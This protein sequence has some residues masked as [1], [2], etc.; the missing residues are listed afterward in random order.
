MPSF[1]SLAPTRLDSS[2]DMSLERQRL[3]L[4]RD[5][6]QNTKDQQR[7]QMELAQMEEGG[8]MAREKMIQ[9]RQLAEQQAA[10]SAAGK[11]ESSAALAKFTE[12]NGQGDIEGARAMVPLMTQLGMQVDLLGEQDGL[13]AYQIGPD[14]EAGSRTQGVIGYPQTDSSPMQAPQGIPSTADAFQQALAS[15]GQPAKPPDQPD[16]TGAVPKNVID[17]GAIHAQTMARLNPAMAG[18]VGSYPQPYQESAQQTANAVGALGLPAGKSIETFDKLRGGPNS[19]IQAGIAADATRGEQGAKRAEAQGKEAFDRLQFGYNSVGKEIGSKHDVAGM[20]ERQ[21]T[22]AQAAY[23]LNNSE[24]SDDYMAGASI[25]RDMG[26]KGVLT[27]GDIKRTLGTASMSFIDRLKT[28]AFKE[29]VGGLAPE[30]KRALNGLID[31]ADKE[32]RKRGM[33][34]LGKVDEFVSDPDTDPDV[35]KGVKNYIRTI[36]PKSLRDEYESVKKKRPGSAASAPSDGAF[37]MEQDSKSEYG[38]GGTEIPHS[39]RIAFDHNNPGN[40]KFAG[41]AG[42]EKGEEAAR[43]GNFARFKTVDAGLDAL[44]QQV[45]KDAERGLTIRDFVMKYAPPS[46]GNDTEQYIKD[47]TR[48]LKAKDGDSLAEVDPYDVV[49]FVA[50]HE[51]GTEM[52]DQYTKSGA[53]PD[54]EARIRELQEKARR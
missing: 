32:D 2:P 29:A 15:Q 4:M 31:Q 42:A 54:P 37:N 33:D 20:I 1:Q 8:R 6:F 22:R 34:M 10:Q 25:A 40:L 7:K 43:G 16:Y 26:E 23:A 24:D 30:Q 9:D 39:S 27:E 17:A 46:D 36:V 19:L 28:G 35:A 3:Q 11:A 44:R 48:E 47:A 38:T 18:I 51:S 53:S 5:E 50:K 49:R 14:P 21:K 12:L 52:P 41:Q 13:P 45:L